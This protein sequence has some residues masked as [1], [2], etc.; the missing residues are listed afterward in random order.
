[1]NQKELKENLK[2]MKLTI[3]FLESDVN[4]KLNLKGHYSDSK[5]N[6]I[7]I[8]NI[9]YVNAIIERINENISFIDKID[10]NKEENKI[11]I[12]KKSLI[13]IILLKHLCDMTKKY[14]IEDHDFEIEN[15]MMH[16]GIP[17]FVSKITKNLKGK[18]KENINEEIEE[19]FKTV[20]KNNKLIEGFNLSS[21]GKF[22]GKIG[23][24]FKKLISGI[25]KIFKFIGG[26]LKKFIMFLWMILK[27]IF[28]FFTKI[29]PKLIKSIF[30]LIRLFILKLVKVGLFCVV[31]FVFLIIALYKYWQTLIEVSKIPLDL[32][33]FPAGMLV[34][35]LFWYQTNTLSKLQSLL[36]GFIMKLL[37]GVFKAFFS[38]V[39]GLPR[40][41]RFFTYKRGN[42][43]KAKFLLT[44]STLFIKMIFKNFPLMMTRFFIGLLMFKYVLKYGTPKIIKQIPSFRE[45]LLFPIIVIKYV[46]SYCIKFYKY[47]F[48]SK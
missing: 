30:N 11:L 20:K 37:S 1:M 33:I 47:V 4:E 28:K 36:I 27:F 22:F 42:Q 29:L 9:S 12:K 10:K 25:G 45:L 17:S 8:R 39:L 23:N 46:I 32:V 14:S 34:I 48:F 19:E 13:N 40:N 6:P 24:G 43:S 21:I 35:Y 18:L 3:K 44:K 16:S 38:Y 41:D 7:I 15:L 26:F 31:I 5:I 2:K